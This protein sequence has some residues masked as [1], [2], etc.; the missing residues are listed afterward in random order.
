MDIMRIG[1]RIQ[2]ADGRVGIIIKVYN[3]HHFIIRIE[4]STETKEIHLQ[5][6]RIG[7]DYV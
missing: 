4:W 2:L 1:K 5:A 6:I 7:S 3:N